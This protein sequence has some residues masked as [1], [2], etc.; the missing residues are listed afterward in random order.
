M[1]LKKRGISLG[2]GAKKISAVGSSRVSAALRLSSG[3]TFAGCGL[4]SRLRVGKAAHGLGESKN[5]LPQGAGSMKLFLTGGTGFI[6]QALVRRFSQRG[7][8][9]QVLVRDADSA[10]AGWIAKQGATLVR[11]DVTNA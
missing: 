9:L 1:A 4:G 8:D 2:A 3:R 5:G 10:P 6:G 7:W 11:G